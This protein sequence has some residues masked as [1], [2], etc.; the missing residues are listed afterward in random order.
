M[1]KKSPGVLFLLSDVIDAVMLLAVVILVNIV[2]IAAA[3]ILGDMLHGT[4]ADNIMMM[5][6]FDLDGSG[7][8]IHDVYTQFQW[9][10]LVLLASGI[11]ISVTANF[12]T[13][14]TFFWR[15][16]ITSLAAAA[17]VIVT[18]PFLWD[19]A[20][21]GMSDLSALI[22]NP[23]YTLDDASPCP[24]SWSDAQIILYHNESP[25]LHEQTATTPQHASDACMPDWKIHYLI[26]QLA[27]DIQYTSGIDEI[28]MEPFANPLE[29]FSL[30]IIDAISDSLTGLAR[31][32]VFGFI[33]SAVTIQFALLAVML[34]VL[35]D[36]L[37]AMI[38]A[39]VPILVMLRL[40][41]IFTRIADKMLFSLPGLFMVPLMSSVILVVGAAAVAS[42]NVIS[43]GY[44]GPV[45]MAAIHAWISSMAV[46]FMSVSIP[47]LM[48]PILEKMFRMATLLVSSAVV[49]SVVITTGV[50]IGAIRGAAVRGRQ[51]IGPVLSGA[52]GGAAG[53]FFHGL[54]KPAKSSD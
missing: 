19:M 29:W 48:V 25:Y 11:T 46:L 26:S 9:L 42:S 36:M 53:G 33:Q 7:N 12:A 16:K 15:S 49:S 20:S 5:P 50:A 14:G 23:A 31:V 17:I 21:A 54:S 39:S 52:A 37:T 28:L 27:G 4:L 3:G 34:T 30:N 10:A 47:I 43:S 2:M 45:S 24:A 38:I 22:L 35:A 8:A 13:G 32:T 18:F 44:I 51:G 40:F 41:P 1:R 6:E